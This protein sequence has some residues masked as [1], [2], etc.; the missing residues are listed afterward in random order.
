MDAPSRKFAG[1]AIGA[2]DPSLPGSAQPLS[3]EPGD[4]FEPSAEEVQEFSHLIEP[5]SLA[6]EG[7]ALSKL[8][9][10]LY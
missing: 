8:P 4:A 1:R 3:D 7:T 5:R 2:V 6:R 9:A 10:L